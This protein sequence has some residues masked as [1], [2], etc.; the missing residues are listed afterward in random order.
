MAEEHPGEAFED[1]H[2]GNSDTGSFCGNGFP[3]APGWDPTT[4]WGRPIW[5]GMLRHFGSDDTAP[6]AH[7]HRNNCSHL[8]HA[9]CA[10]A[11]RASAGNCFLC[12]SR[13]VDIA[14]ICSEAAVDAF[15]TKKSGG[16]HL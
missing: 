3:A 11:Q 1:V 15:C 7:G 6:A 13:H 14:A 5:P 4:G 16:T 8:A 12:C 2:V 10:D 9:R